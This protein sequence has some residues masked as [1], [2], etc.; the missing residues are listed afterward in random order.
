[1]SQQGTETRVQRRLARQR[2]L[3]RRRLAVSVVVVGVAAVCLLVVTA[4][5]PGHSGRQASSGRTP[6]T[7]AEAHTAAAPD[8]ADPPSAGSPATFLSSNGVESRAIIAEN[9]RPGTTAWKITNTATTGTIAGFA[10]RNY[11]ADGE[12][13][14]LYVSTSAASFGVVAYRMGY[15][16]GTGGREVWSS[17][18]LPGQQQPTCPVDHTT[19]MVSCDNWSRSTTVQVTTQWPAG[20]YVLK[21]T[22][23]ANDQAYVLLT[24][25][26][27]SSRATY[28]LVNRTLTEQGWNTL[29][30]Y[31]FYQGLGSCILDDDGYPPCNRARV[32]SLDRPYAEGDGAEDFFGN[33][34]PLIYWM[35]E[36]GLDV[37]YATDIT[38][39]ENPGFALQHRA[40]LSLD[41]D[42]TWTYNELQA[43]KKAMS[44]GA[45]ILFLS[46]AAI[47]RHGRLEPSPL[48]ADREE[49]D[50]RN[51]GED[52]E[53]HSGDPNE[54]TP[55]TWDAAD[56]ALTGQEYS[57]YI[58]PGKP[59]APMVVYDASSWVF[60]GT[61]LH[62]GSQIP[63]AIGSDI[64][65]L[66]RAG[67]LV[68]NDLQV[69]AHSPI[70][71]TEAYTNQ[72][73]WSGDTYSD[74]TYYT[75]PVSGAGVIDTGDTTFIGDLQSC[76]TNTAGCQPAL[77]RIVGNMLRV[78]GQG[79]A[80][81]IAPPEANWHSVTPYGS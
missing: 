32:V 6:V 15:Y 3:R 13:F 1:M 77:L 62:D 72:G 71:L 23:S 14:G 34:Y 16:Q 7:T 75:D 48:G 22:D 51:A 43:A 26:D 20:D 59:Q 61:G 29:G 70:P 68:P 30:G 17:G 49:V 53:S 24:V 25:W 44:Q 11:V 28:L 10:D 80:G 56:S 33:E 37:T 63:D 78:F 46:G 9:Q 64:D 60:A 57:G 2:R 45:N 54:V 40:W 81:R 66:D 36:Q 50:Y 27:P 69:L 76:T 5:L 73:E 58:L 8:G 65:H 12:S 18:Q 42:E 41:H 4:V 21:L 35:E 52:P 31:D 39:T 19:N 38:L 67:G 55:N 47:V 74:F 79:P